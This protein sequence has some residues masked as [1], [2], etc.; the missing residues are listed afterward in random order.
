MKI[1]R[2][3]R[4]TILLLFVFT[5]F[6]CTPAFAEE[7]DQTQSQ[8]LSNMDVLTLGYVYAMRGIICPLA[9]VSLA[10]CGFKILFAVFA[11][12]RAD[13]PKIKKQV[14]WTVIGIIAFAMLPTIVRTAISMIRS[15][16][17][18]PM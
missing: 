10:S 13:M 17:W 16:A 1:R 9:I 15:A 4:A 3:L 6:L 8:I 7:T 5:A 11:G 18:K 12:G 14:I 2:Y